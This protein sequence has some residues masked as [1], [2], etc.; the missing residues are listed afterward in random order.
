MIDLNI[1]VLLG[2]I[3]LTYA[4]SER[5]ATL[6]DAQSSLRLH[7]A[8]RVQLVFIHCHAPMEHDQA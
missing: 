1:H 8:V 4:N 6:K 7:G 5:S 2:F 3:F